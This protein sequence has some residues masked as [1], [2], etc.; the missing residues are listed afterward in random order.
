MVPVARAPVRAGS[1][2]FLNTPRAMGL[3]L[4]DA[5]EPVAADMATPGTAPRRGRRAQGPEWVKV[6]SVDDI[7]KVGPDEWWRG[8]AHTIERM[9]HEL[10][11][12]D[13]RRLTVFQD[14]VSG[15]WFR[16]EDV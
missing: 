9:Y 3:R 5:G 12:E 10:R 13:G 8:P 11:L 1:L 6:R 15:D 2:K 4:S 14:M 16:Q 7:W